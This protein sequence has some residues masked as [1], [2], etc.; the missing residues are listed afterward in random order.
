MID[1]DAIP[2]DVPARERRPV[3]TV[4]L[5]TVWPLP[6]G[7]VAIV[8]HYDAEGRPTLAHGPHGRRKRRQG[9]DATTERDRGER[10]PRAAL[11][12]KT[13]ADGGMFGHCVRVVRERPA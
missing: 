6:D 9:Q 11:Q 5:A 3:G 4:Y 8:P 13:V 12:G 2:L 7:G 1:V 10:G